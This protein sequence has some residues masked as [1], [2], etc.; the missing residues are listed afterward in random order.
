M[1]TPIAL[2]AGSFLTQIFDRLGYL[3]P[4]CVLVGAGCGLP[5]PEEVTL[6]GSGFLLHQER[7]ELAW[8]V[9]TCY[10]GTLAGD[11]VPFWLGRKLGMSMMEHPLLAKIFHPERRALLV[12]RFRRH[13]HWAVFSCR[14]L[15]GVRLP[16]FFTAGTLRMTYARF[17]LI[18]GLAA[19][20]MVPIW[21]LIGRAFGEEI[22]RLESDVGHLEQI[23]GLTLLALLF[24]ASA[25]VLVRRRERRRTPRAAEERAVEAEVPRAGPSEPAADA[26]PAAEHGATP[27][28]A[29]PRAGHG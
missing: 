11:S 3:A 6:L 5:V 19:V 24:V 2:A 25:H 17:L 18:D 12:D 14:F 22:E 21:I 16:G 4:F 9:L 13:G 20:I 27:E 23:L 10:V 28:A 7:V 8:I 1:T 26:P 29:P 15:P